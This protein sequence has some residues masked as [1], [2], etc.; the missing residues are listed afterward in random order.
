MFFSSQV[1]L[2]IS[3]AFD[4]EVKFPVVIVPPGFTSGHHPAVT[5]D[6]YP[7]GA[8][9][10]PSNSDFSPPRVAMSPYSV[11]PHAGRYGHPGAQ[12]YSSPPPQYPAQPA[13]MSAGYNNPVPTPYGDP[14]S[15]PSS[16]VH[17][18]PTAPPPPSAPAIQ[19]PPF[20]PQF[21]SSPSAP[22]YNMLPSAPAMNTDFLSQ[23]D[24]APPAYS[25]LFPSSAA[26]ESDAK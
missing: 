9:G 1:Y 20:S 14:F 22:A 3:F 23:S 18:P 15:S 19:P 13:Y 7:A 12:S 17:P 16:V 5:A 26:G 2:D 8:F 10:G 6:P 24:E 4:P 25:V 21:Y 11:S